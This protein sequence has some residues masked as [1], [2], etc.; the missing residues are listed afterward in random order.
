MCP[1]PSR[2]TSFSII[3]TSSSLRGSAPIRLRRA[4]SSFLDTNPSSS[5][6]VSL[7]AC[8]SSTF[9][10][11]EESDQLPNISGKTLL[12][13]PRLVMPTPEPGFW[14]DVDASELDADDVPEPKEDGSDL[15]TEDRSFLDRNKRVGLTMR[16]FGLSWLILTSFMAKMR[17]PKRQRNSRKKRRKE[18]EEE[19]RFEWKE[20]GRMGC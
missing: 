14:C 16:F 7:N 5:L 3:F 10:S 8:A 13:V 4:C 1:S 12:G 19:E 6:S 18:R 2:S 11:A 15:D 20:G 9:I 17:E